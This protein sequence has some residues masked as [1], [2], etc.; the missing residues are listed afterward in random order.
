M[1]HIR[2]YKFD[3]A[4]IMMKLLIHKYNFL[5]YKGKGEGRPRTGHEGPEGRLRYNSTLSLT[6]ALNGVGGQRHS[7]AALPPA[8]RH[9]THCIGGWMGPRAGLEWCGRSR[10]RRDLITLPSS[11]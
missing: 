1:T 11:P 9:S 6:S 3:F 8:K 5:Q 10:R 2:C 7:L 4:P